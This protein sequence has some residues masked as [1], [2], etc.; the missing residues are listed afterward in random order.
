M[1]LNHLAHESD[2]A[3]RRG[4]LGGAKD[5]RDVNDSEIVL[6]RTA[7][8]D[9]KDIVGKDCAGG[10]RIVDVETD[11]EMSVYLGLLVLRRPFSTWG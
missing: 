10:G 5:S 2:I 9:L 6:L 8:L 4:T 3:L 11:S 7:D 1:R